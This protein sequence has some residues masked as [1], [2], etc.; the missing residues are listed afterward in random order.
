MEQEYLDLIKQELLDRQEEL[1]RRCL[2]ECRRR[3][4]GSPEES[5]ECLANLMT[6]E[7][8]LDNA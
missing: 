1:K 3:C 7:Y 8:L 6:L 5:M 2:E 4:G